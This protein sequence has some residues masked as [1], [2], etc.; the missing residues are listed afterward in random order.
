M[1][2]DEHPE[3]MWSSYVTEIDG[4]WLVVHTSKDTA[5][6]RTFFISNFCPNVNSICICHVLVPIQ[7]YL[8]SIA[9]LHTNEIGPNMKWIKVA[10]TFEAY[11]GM[12]A[13]LS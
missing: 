4:R 3:Y 5:R 2:D 9:D 1:K 7:K 6:V 13:Y 12:C 11:Y 10:T 8:L